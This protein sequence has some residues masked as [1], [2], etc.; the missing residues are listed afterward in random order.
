MLVVSPFSAGGWV[1]SDTFDHTSQLQFIA[2]RFGVAI[3]NVSSWRLGA[4]G[5]LAAALPT[6]G[7]PINTSPTLAA[8]HHSINKPPIAG[9]CNSAQLL[10][11]NTTTPAYPI[12][13]PQT[14]PTQG[15]DTLEPTKPSSLVRVRARTLRLPSSD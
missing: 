11:L 14:Q 15:P 3:P 6:L 4:V 12:P 9:E 1:C 2:E 5:D 7:T 10:E 13:M 8:T